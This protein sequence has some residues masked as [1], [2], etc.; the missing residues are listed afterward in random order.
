MEARLFGP[1]GKPDTQFDTTHALLGFYP[2]N[3][4]KQTTPSLT[5]TQNGV[6]CFASRAA[7][8]DWG[9]VPEGEPRMIYLTDE[10]VK[11]HVSGLRESHPQVFS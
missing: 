10:Q 5:R 4:P 1:D 7:L 6:T 2:K 9:I 11:T 8:T 3:R